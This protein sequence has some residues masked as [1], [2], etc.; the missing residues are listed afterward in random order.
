MRSLRVIQIL[1]KYYGDTVSRIF[2]GYYQRYVITG[3]EGDGPLGIVLQFRGKTIL[4][5][6]GTGDGVGAFEVNIQN[7]AGRYMTMISEPGISAMEDYTKKYPGIIGSYQEELDE[8]DK[9]K[10]GRRFR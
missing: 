10:L 4:G 8:P 1:I 9:K 3:I 6:D 2:E 5:F 7:E